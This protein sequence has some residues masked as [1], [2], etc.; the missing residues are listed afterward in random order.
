ML[1]TTYMCKNRHGVYYARFIIP[2]H[3]QSHFNNKK[4][5]RRTLQ[6][7]SRKLAI[8]RARIYRVEFEKIVDELMSKSDKTSER[9]KK[10]IDELF[11]DKTKLQA[12]AEKKFVDGMFAKSV[13]NKI[14]IDGIR[15][16]YITCFDALGQLVTIDTGNAIEDVELY[17]TIAPVETERDRAIREKREEE[18][19]QAT[20]KAIAAPPH[21][22]A[23]ARTI[24]PKLLSEYFD[25][26]AKYQNKSKGENDKVDRKEGKG[27]QS[28]TARNKENPQRKFIFKYCDK[29]AAAFTWED[30]ER[31][32]EIMEVMPKNFEN[33]SHSQIFKG[34]TIEMLLDVDVDTSMYKYETRATSTIYVNIGTFRAFLNW[35]AKK[36]KVKELRDAIETL[37]EARKEMN[38]E[39]KK[40][41]FEP[42]ELKT[43]FEDNNPADENYVK[44]FIS[45]RVIDPNLKYWLPLLA[46]YT[47]ATLAELCQLHLSDVYQHKAFDGSEHWIIDFNKSENKRLKNKFR[48]RLIPV[49]KVLINLGFID[50]VQSLSLTGEIELFPTAK[51]SSGGNGF[52]MTEGQW[53]GIYSDNAGI[54]DK[55]VTFHSFRHVIATYLDKIHCESAI[56]SAILG[57]AIQS[58][59]TKNYSKGGYRVKDIAPLVVAIN[60]IDY[61][62]NHHPFKLAV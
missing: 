32:I 33:P 2:K 43:L 62:L 53:W 47:G 48:A 10:I 9:A 58:T 21:F 27:W 36:Q 7:D 25:D 50:H 16:D 14:D 46:L 6:T 39:S 42:E 37:D 18:L 28:D 12:T 44:G 1:N 60:K 55:D 35:V 17:K 15:I 61:G 20:L 3:L 30:A 45:K 13:S 40:R 22:T 56:M 23:P 38:I 52:F 26:Y 59:L 19:H 8:K 5:V 57:H 31:V 49:S 4:E 24:N 11:A 51:R 54:T 34:L 41:H 29:P